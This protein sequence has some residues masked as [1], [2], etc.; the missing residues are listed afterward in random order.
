MQSEI[1][2]SRPSND[3]GTDHLRATS[4]ARL[5]ARRLFE[6]DDVLVK[7]VISFPCR[8]IKSRASTRGIIA[9]SDGSI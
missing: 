9:D 1:P 8:F 4:S 3:D 6:Y 5:S 2:P 7:R